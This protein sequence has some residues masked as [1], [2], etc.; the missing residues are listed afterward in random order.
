MNSPT[1]PL[2]RA[3]KE[4]TRALFD[5][6]QRHLLFQERVMPCF[7]ECARERGRSESDL[8][9]LSLSGAVIARDNNASD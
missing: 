8:E 1:S 2:S 4:N 7:D 6:A 5:P 3:R 9:K